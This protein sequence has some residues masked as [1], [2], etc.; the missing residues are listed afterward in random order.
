[1]SCL[2]WTVKLKSVKKVTFT[3]AKLLAEVVQEK[4]RFSSPFS[5][6]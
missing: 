3:R 1:M 6:L 5:L 2:L 4:R